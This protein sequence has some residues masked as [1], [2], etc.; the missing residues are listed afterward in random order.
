MDAVDNASL[1]TTAKSSVIP[2][3]PAKQTPVKSQITLPK[4]VLEQLAALRIGVRLISTE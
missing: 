1:P 2:V 4:D 3:A